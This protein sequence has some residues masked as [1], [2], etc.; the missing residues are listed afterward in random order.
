MNK[1]LL[2]DLRSVIIFFFLHS[3]VLGSFAE[4]PRAHRGTVIRGYRNRESIGSMLR[5]PLARERS[6]FENGRK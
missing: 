2:E 1:L 4:E 3:P 6:R 5:I